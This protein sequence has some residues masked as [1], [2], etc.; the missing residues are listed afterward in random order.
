[1][2]SSLNVYC[3]LFQLK[4]YFEL[5][6]KIRQRKI[7]LAAISKIGSFISM[8]DLV[9]EKYPQAVSMMAFMFLSIEYPIMKTFFENSLNSVIFGYE[10]I[11]TLFVG[12]TTLSI[13][14]A[15]KRIRNVHRLPQEPGFLGL[16]LQI[17]AILFLLTPKIVFVSNALIFAPFTF[18]IGYT[19]ELLLVLGYNWVISGKIQGEYRIVASTKTCYYSENQI[20]NSFE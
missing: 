13:V 11:L 7:R 2:E 1:M 4:A 16:V 9:L 14:L 3:L 18:P 8:M 5:N 17:L 19:L 20:F 10:I 12:G 15:L 6:E